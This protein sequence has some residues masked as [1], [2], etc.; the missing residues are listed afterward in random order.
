[1]SAITHNMFEILDS[2]DMYAKNGTYV[3]TNTS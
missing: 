3:E 1:M 2:A